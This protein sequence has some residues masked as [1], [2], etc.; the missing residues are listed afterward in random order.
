MP[1]KA[2]LLS[3]MARAALKAFGC[4][5]VLLKAG[6][7][8]AGNNRLRALDMESKSILDGDINIVPIQGSKNFAYT[9]RWASRESECSRGSRA[10]ACEH[11][12]DR[13]SAPFYLTL[14]PEQLRQEGQGK[15]HNLL[16]P[17]QEKGR[18]RRI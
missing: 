4:A 7:Y 12:V 1:Q 2:L 14:Q 13:A 11:G 8:A 10:G 6:M 15:D 3:V 5:L 17:G 18:R 9:S 16:I